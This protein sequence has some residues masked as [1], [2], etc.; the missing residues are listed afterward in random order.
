[1]VHIFTIFEVFREGPDL[2]CPAVASSIGVFIR[3]YTYIE[4]YLGQVD[5]VSGLRVGGKGSCSH[6]GQVDVQGADFLR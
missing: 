4:S 3:H 1:M 2:D 6:D 5:D